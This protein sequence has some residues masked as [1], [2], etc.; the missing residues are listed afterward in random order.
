VGGKDSQ[1][2]RTDFRGSG[3]ISEA[4]ELRWRDVDLTG[5]KLRVV[6]AKTDAGVR[7]VDLTPALRE[8]LS[9]YHERSGHAGPDDFVFPTRD[10]NR[11]DA[12]NVRTRFLAAAVELANA[13]LREAGEDLIGK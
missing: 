7:E 6:E 5:R 2:G 4:L 11:D 12:S 13:S 9:E 3:Q 10:G 1:T 8:M